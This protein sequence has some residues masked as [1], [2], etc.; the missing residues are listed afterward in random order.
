MI[1]AVDFINY[2]LLTFDDDGH[3]LP[4]VVEGDF[5]SDAEAI[6]YSRLQY[7]NLTVEVWCGRRLAATVDPS[8]DGLYERE[9]QSPFRARWL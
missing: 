7:P 1:K 8:G 2:R 3:L 5:R 6:D 9:E 4:P